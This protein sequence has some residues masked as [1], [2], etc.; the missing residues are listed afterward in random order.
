MTAATKIDDA[1]ASPNGCAAPVGALPGS[2]TWGSNDVRE[3]LFA[4]PQTWPG[5]RS[6]LRKK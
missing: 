2:G 5:E 4:V 1:T 6:R 3:V